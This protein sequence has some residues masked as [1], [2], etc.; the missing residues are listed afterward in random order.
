MFCASVTVLHT[1]TQRV[2]TRQDSPVKHHH[3]STPA[4]LHL[5]THGLTVPLLTTLQYTEMF[6]ILQ[7][8][9]ASRLWRDIQNNFN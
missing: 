7:Y 3:L 4:K 5:C 9:E 1:V 6:C 2:T 8:K